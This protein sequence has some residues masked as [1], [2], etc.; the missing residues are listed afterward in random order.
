M[1]PTPQQAIDVANSVFGRHPGYR[2]LHAKGTLC[3]GAFTPTAHAHELTRATH[4]E[5]PEVPVTVRFSNGSGDPDHPDWAPDP[6]GLAIKLYLPDGSRT[7][8]VGVSSPR[9][10]TRTPEGFIELVEARGAGAAAAW[11]LPLFIVRHP[12]AVPVLPVVAPT[13]M[14]PASYATIPYYGL[15]AFRWIDASGGERYVRYTL[16]PA[17]SAP[18]PGPQAL[19]RLGRN[20]LQD[21]ISKRVEAEPVLF[22]L[23]VQIAAPGDRVED[24]SSA[25]PK[26]RR[27]VTVGT[28]K[29]DRLEH[30]REQ[31]GDI[32]V[33]DPSRVT[34]GIECSDDP[35][36]RFRPHAY[37]E[38]VKRR[39]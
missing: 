3:A 2:A 36:L 25:W 38:S 28:L 21:E 12:E 17:A 1:A 18:R 19:R 39:A 5:G 27:R 26:Q 14:A 34:D 37:S 32:L 10:V 29:I 22:S 7:D 8:I 11:K 35:V 16:R 20:Y 9:F 23:E 31:G 4:M 33:F 30:D 6:R 15:H 13:L 24:P